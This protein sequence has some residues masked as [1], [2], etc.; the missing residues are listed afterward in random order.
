MSR[1]IL[2]LSLLLL[3]SVPV[4]GLSA[5]DPQLMTDHAWYPGELSCSNFTRL[6]ARQASVYNR[7]T[8]R[9]ANN[10]EDKAIASWYW[11]MYNYYHFTSPEEYIYSDTATDGAAIRDYWDGLFSYGFALCGTTHAQY[12]AEMEYLLGHAKGRVVGVAGHNSHEAFLTGGSYGAGQWV[13]LDQDEA[14]IV[15]HNQVTPDY[16]LGIKDIVYSTYN[17]D[18]L[19]RVMFPAATRENTL[20]NDGAP[21]VNRGWFISNTYFPNSNDN[22]ASSDLYGTLAD[23]VTLEPLSGYAG[24]PPIVALNRGETFRRYLK[25]GLGG[26]TYVFWSAYGYAGVPGPDCA[27][28]WCNQPQ[29]LYRA[30]AHAPYN[31][32]QGEYGN[33]V[34]TYTPNFSD[35]SYQDGVISESGSQ[36]TF[37]FYSPYAIGAKP[38]VG[39]T[40][41]WAVKNAGCSEGLVLTASAAGVGVQVS[42]NNG[43]TWSG[44]QTLNN[45]LDLTDLVKGHHSY[46]LRF[47]AG[48]S[49]LTGKNITMKTV[50]MVNDRLIPHLKDSGSVVTYQASGKAVF[51][52]GPNKDQ[53]QAYVTAGAF[54]AGSPV[55]MTV[56]APNGAKILEVYAAAWVSSSS[57]PN[58]AYNYNI[59]YSTNG[60]ANWY[61][62]LQN[63]KIDLLGYQSYDYWSQSFCYGNKDISVA[64]ASSVMVRF[65]NDGGKGYRKA[66][67]YLVY[68][69]TNNQTVD[70][71]FNWNDSI[72]TG[73]SDT[74]TYPAGQTTP[75][76]TWTVATGTSTVT[77]WVEMKVN[78][79]PPDPDKPIASFTY[80]PASPVVVNDTVNFTDTSSP[81]APHNLTTWAWDFGDGGT[82]TSNAPSHQ[83]TTAGTYTI[84][85]TVTNDAAK[86]DT[87]TRSITISAGGTPVTVTFQQGTSG[88][89]GCQD[90]YIRCLIPTDPDYS[91]HGYLEDMQCYNIA[92][93]I[94]RILVQFDLVDLSQ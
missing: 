18:P 23:L 85:L 92:S 91:G 82:S 87:T 43:T 22:A 37:Y 65:S 31:T 7:E 6:F 21:N 55:T 77:N 84:T 79:A 53:A 45:T 62:I 61:Y 64:N 30:T 46:M 27:R 48:A 38:P 4:F 2:A 49:S 73:R 24:V 80:A 12:T 17:T 71:T 51:A 94:T 3:C 74:H 15:F 13:L 83:Y 78:A 56:P 76:S 14:G 75:D 8:T 40:S 50:V 54:D 34:Y 28:T 36:V 32:T 72:G 39:D 60:G 47:N 44:A 90:T 66:D 20:D 89:T 33:G 57:P 93:Y 10:D 35:T 11:R 5:G 29:G 68:Q 41:T 1:R 52:A 9:T 67:V 25:P 26:T 81:P 70:V 16:L 86:T 59:E 19:L 63:S 88:Y 69:T 42:T 58:P